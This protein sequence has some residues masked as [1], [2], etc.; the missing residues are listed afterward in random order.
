MCRVALFGLCGDARRPRT[1]Y[2]NDVGVVYE[3]SA[4]GDQAL[5]NFPQMARGPLQATFTA[6]RSLWRRRDLCTSWTPPAR[7]RCC[8]RSQIRRC[9]TRPGGCNLWYCHGWWRQQRRL[10]RGLPAHISA[11]TDLAHAPGVPC[12]HSCRHTRAKL[13]PGVWTFCDPDVAHALSVPRP[14]SRGRRGRSPRLEFGHL[15]PMW[16]THPACRVATPGDAPGVSPAIP[17]AKLAGLELGHLVLMW[18]THPACR[19]ATPGDAPGVSPA[20]EFGHFR[21]TW[22]SHSYPRASLAG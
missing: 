10:G 2:L 17:R 20:L 15:V 18:R 9:N 4:S 16:R 12:R 6:P 14:H 22:R 11:V 1:G 7:K 19:V 8:I 21:P 3:Q 13:A 5:S